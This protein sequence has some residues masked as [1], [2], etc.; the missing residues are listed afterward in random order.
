MTH[1][2]RLYL[3]HG[4]VLVSDL[5]DVLDGE[6]AMLTSESTATFR[7]LVTWSPDLAADDVQAAHLALLDRAKLRNIDIREQR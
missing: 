2:Q 5:Y 1:N 3:V 6:T 7:L 4:A